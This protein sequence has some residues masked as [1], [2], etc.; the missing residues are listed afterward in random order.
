MLKKGKLRDEDK[1]DLNLRKFDVSITI[2]V[3]V[4]QSCKYKCCRR[5]LTSK[6]IM[7]QNTD[8][9]TLDL[10]VLKLTTTQ[11]VILSKNL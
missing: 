1:Q 9:V 2:A 5:P 8:L 6:K 10:R 4:A 3:D 11:C 7:V